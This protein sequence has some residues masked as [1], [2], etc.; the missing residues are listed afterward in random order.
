MSMLSTCQTAIK[1]TT[2]LIHA[3][4][5]LSTQRIVKKTGA[6]GLAVP[7][8]R[9]DLAVLVVDP[10]IDDGGRRGPLILVGLLRRSRI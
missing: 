3:H 9:N 5:P 6:P 4:R 7:L 10:M 8:L 2:T 1:A